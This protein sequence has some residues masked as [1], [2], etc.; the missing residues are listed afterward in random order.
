MKKLLKNLI[1]SLDEHLSDDRLASFVCG[2]LSLTDRWI[3]RRH[4]AGCWRCRLHK[5][6][7]EGPRSRRML[8][9]DRQIL[10]SEKLS[11]EP[12][13]EFSL[14][15]R[16]HLENITS[17]E[18]RTHRSGNTRGLLE[19]PL[20]ESPRLKPV[21]MACMVFG[22]ATVLSFG[23]WQLQHASRVPSNTFLARAERWD[24]P[25]L[26]STPSVVF[27]SVRV[28]VSNQ[29]KK[30][31]K[32]RSI[33]RDSQGKR[34]A[35]QV[36]LDATEQQLN[37]ALNQAEMDW[38]EPLSATDYR[39]WHDHQ[40]VRADNVVREG[41]HL[42]RLTTTVPDGPVAEQSLTVRDT[43]FHPVKR[44]VELRDSSTVEIAEL[45]FKILP[46]AAVDANLFEPIGGLD[47][48]I[49]RPS[50]RVLSFPRVQDTPSESQLDDAELGA[51]LI[52]NRLHADTGEQIKV[53]RSQGIV[54]AD[55]VVESE[56]RKQ[57]LRTQLAMVPHLRVSIRS[58]D[59]LGKTPDEGGAV[60]SVKSATMPDQPSPLELY[61]KA[62]GRSVNGVNGLA[63]RFFN[64]ALTISQ[65]SKSIADLETLFANEN[66]R[67]VIASAT[68]TELIYSHRER[69]QEAL[70][71]ERKLLCEVR[72]SG[73]GNG[74]PANDR[75]SLLK[76]P[77]RNLALSR[78]LIGTDSAV[79][80][81]AV[82]ILSEMSDTVEELTAALRVTYE[83][84]QSNA[85]LSGKN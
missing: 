45:D 74:P 37:T 5:E 67:T 39:T 21:L 50:A 7:L 38:N 8:E 75:L 79:P 78:E 85:A 48:A 52:L 17:L 66:Q 83:K 36:K 69:L 9:L 28:I 32:I 30:E 31:T 53:L 82:S 49:A 14:K 23:V 80:R 20:F 33:Y 84:P 46:W 51:L 25:N 72:P 54:E 3:A 81:N 60:S 34:R 57:E 76:G 26:A 12:R 71:E 77:D 18:E 11:E 10:A 40:R 19:F 6:D 63:E 16:L 35:K 64:S 58:V 61:L 56:E 55:G 43:D 24:A 29:S 44:T 68:L 70:A 73:S 62:R 42:L 2:E 13:T 47:T 27:Q 22:I 4:L 65:E 1:P 59:D 15:L 41:S